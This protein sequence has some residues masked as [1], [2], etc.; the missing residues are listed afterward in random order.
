MR[1]GCPPQQA[2]SGWSHAWT[3]GVP[4]Y[5]RRMPRLGN[6]NGGTS[7]PDP[8]AAMKAEVLA[9][10]PWVT[11]AQ[12][13]LLDEYAAKPVFLVDGYTPLQVLEWFQ[14]QVAPLVKQV[15]FTQGRGGEFAGKKFRNPG[16]EVWFEV[17]KG[18]KSRFVHDKVFIANGPYGGVGR[19]CSGTGRTAVEDTAGE[20]RNSGVSFPSIIYTPPLMRAWLRRSSRYPWGTGWLGGSTEPQL[21]FIIPETYGQYACNKDTN[22]QQAK[23]ENQQDSA[24]NAAIQQAISAI[25]MGQTTEASEAQGE[26]AEDFTNRIPQELLDRIEAADAKLNAIDEREQ[27]QAL[28]AE[29]RAAASDARKELERELLTLQAQLRAQQMTRGAGELSLRSPIVLGGLGILALGGLYFA[30]R[31]AR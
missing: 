17:A 6:Q 15:E 16:Q 2:L 27:N 9:A 7:A 3:I 26:A 22:R 19:F 20:F 1:L 4:G 24:Y 21:H 28:A 25:R 8:A 11:D 14:N 18:L 29:E 10:Y 30:T 5:H 31:S 12:Y 23:I 13:N